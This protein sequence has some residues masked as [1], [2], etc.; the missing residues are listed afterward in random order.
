[1]SSNDPRSKFFLSTSIHTHTLFSVRFSSK[2]Q[3]AERRNLR[4][5]NLHSRRET[6]GR[7][8]RFSIPALRHASSTGFAL[9]YPTSCLGE[10]TFDCDSDV[11]YDSRYN[12]R[13]RHLEQTIW[14]GDYDSNDRWDEHHTSFFS[15]FETEQH[16]GTEQFLTISCA[17]QHEFLSTTLRSTERYLEFHSGQ[18]RAGLRE[19]VYMEA[20]RWSIWR[21]LVSLSN[22]QQKT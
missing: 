3:S 1:M 19:G 18:L 14:L 10:C 15:I 5:C 16:N 22:N 4:F 12:Y 11:N 17:E 21:E 8:N 7:E 2:T 13:H 6:R 9:R 20:F